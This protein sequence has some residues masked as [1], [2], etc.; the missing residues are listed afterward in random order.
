MDT[1]R[2]EIILIL[3]IISLFSC[4]RKYTHVMDIAETQMM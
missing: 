2:R 3:T 4:G 1:M